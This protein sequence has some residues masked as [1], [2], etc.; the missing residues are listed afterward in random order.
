MVRTPGIV[1]TPLTAE[2]IAENLD[3][4][5][6]ISDAQVTAVTEMVQ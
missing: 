2:D 3:A 4:V 6:D 5:M 1:R